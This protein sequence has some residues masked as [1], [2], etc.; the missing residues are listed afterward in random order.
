MLDNNTIEG[1]FRVLRVTEKVRNVDHRLN[2]DSFHVVQIAI[3]GLSPDQVLRLHRA[4]VAAEL[5]QYHV[6]FPQLEM[7]AFLQAAQDFAA[8]V[9]SDVDP[10][11]G[12]IKG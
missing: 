9:R 12:E 4:L 11:T 8:K 10:E 3:E 6:V 2:K 1:T 7:P 5:V